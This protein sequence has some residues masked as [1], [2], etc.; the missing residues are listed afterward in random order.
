MTAYGSLDVTIEAIKL[1]AYYY[2]EKPYTP[3]FLRA[4]VE[5]AVQFSSL[6]REN[7]NLKRTPVPAITKRL[8]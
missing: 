6:K 7:E 1:G 2:L 3:D 8:A 4:L 5:R